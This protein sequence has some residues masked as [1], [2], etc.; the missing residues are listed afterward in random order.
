M[1]SQ[2][3]SVASTPTVNKKLPSYIKIFS[4][5]DDFVTGPTCKVPH[6]VDGISTAFTKATGWQLAPESVD[7]DENQPFT[8]AESATDDRVSREDADCLADMI[9]GLF[10]ELTRTQRAL[11][12]REGELAAA[13]PLVSRPEDEQFQMAERLQA[14][15]QGAA[16]AVSCQAAGL[17]LLDED[18]SHLKLRSHWG[19]PADRLVAAARR[20][21]GS[22]AD[23]E[24]LTGHAVV[25]ERADRFDVWNAP[26]EYA[27]AIC[28][29]VST[30]TVPLGTLW[31]FG[32][33][34]QS[35]SDAQ[36]NLIEIIA[37]RLACELEREILLRERAEL[38]PHCESDPAAPASWQNQQWMGVVAADGW[39][40]V[41]VAGERDRTSKLSGDSWTS[42]E[43]EDGR[44]S[45]TLGAA[46]QRGVAGA[47]TSAMFGGAAQLV[48]A[49]LDPAA[50]LNRINDA[51]AV[52]SAG[53][54]AC[55]TVGVTLTPDA[56]EIQFSTAGDIRL[57]VIRPHGWE[58]VGCPSPAVGV[59]TD[60]IYQPAMATLEAGDVLLAVASAPVR[61]SRR[62]S[63][64][65]LGAKD[66]AESFLHHHHLS[67]RQLAELATSLLD[68]K[69]HV[70]PHRPALLIA[71][72]EP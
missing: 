24:A 34:E 37:G 42:Y 13:V 59:T 39:Q 61:A 58:V 2:H 53:D 1:V 15:L 52:L 23:L 55:T 4:G 17:Y 49:T 35:F 67:P 21:R 20:L 6:L 40:T 12:E 14:V 9:G 45:L 57:F 71:R 25:L 60:A 63:E 19:L 65:Y 69:P 56:D 54:Q 51:V 47:V 38:A 30:A 29:P 7:I 18:T 33:N 41:A 27:C 62:D 22:K 46:H 50:R 16:D 44:L 11:W 43:F 64:Q 68:S 48:R 72:R 5:D 66:L 28:V 3:T 32:T 70:W 10:D 31:I 26:E 8:V 36:V